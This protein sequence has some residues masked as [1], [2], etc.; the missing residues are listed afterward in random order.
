MKKS[1]LKSRVLFTTQVHFLRLLMWAGNQICPTLLSIPLNHFAIKVGASLCS[2]QSFLAPYMLHT[3]MGVPL[4]VVA[5]SNAG[6]QKG[7]LR[8]AG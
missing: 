1:K 3:L 4:K 6:A 2:I 5:G 8:A 7:A